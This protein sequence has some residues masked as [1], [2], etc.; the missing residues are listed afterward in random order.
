MKPPLGRDVIV[1][2]ALRQ[3]T[4]DGLKGM[5]LRRV[6]AALETGP[7]S[8]YAYVDD[9]EALHALVLD[10]A[11]EGVDTRK[12]AKSGWR[13]R[14]F[15][16]LESYA[17]VL[18]ASKGLAQLAF[19]AVA[20][21]P[22]ALRIIEAVMALLQ[23]GG[24]DVATAAWAVDLL[25]LYVTAVVAEH[26]GGTDPV[27]PEGAVSRAIRGVSEQQYPRIHAARDDLLSGEPH[28]RF[29]WAVDVLLEGIQKS[30]RAATAKRGRPTTKTRLASR[31]RRQKQA[32]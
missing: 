26:S 30:P 27:A 19:G 16:V 29:R 25:T 22:N 7:A 1:T 12:T 14:L 13:D 23:E 18:S 8:L 6:A 4:E 2:E 28:E 3:L 9:L 10:R 5:S 17:R 20:I 32:R 11:L 21:G 31:R 15:Q 24:V